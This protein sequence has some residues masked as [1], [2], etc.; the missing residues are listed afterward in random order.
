MSARLVLAL[1]AGTAPGHPAAGESVPAPLNVPLVLVEVGAPPPSFS[2]ERLAVAVETYI[3]GA[4]PRMMRLHGVPPG[5]AEVCGAARA[6]A[7]AADAAFAIWFGWSAADTSASFS[8]F[9]LPVAADCSEAVSYSVTY[10]ESDTATFYRV[11][12]LKL[13]SV[14]REARA[15]AL[16]PSE[17]PA[18]LP[19][20]QPPPAVTVELATPGALFLELGAASVL[21]P[22]RASRVTFVQAA[23]DLRDGVW[24]FGVLGFG[25]L[26][27]Q[28]ETSTA[29]ARAYVGGLVILARRAL[30]RL[31]DEAGPFGL[32]AEAGAG[33]QGIWASAQRRG[34]TQRYSLQ[35]FT[36]LF[37]AALTA[38]VTLSRPLALRFGPGVDLSWEDLT[39]FANGTTLVHSPRARPRC[40]LRLEASF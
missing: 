7:I 26:P 6:M 27:V 12:A 5:G 8:L 16:P 39:L 29:S 25:A 18:T 37:A 17:A 34:E 24:A 28:R 14:V 40:D 38:R 22:E 35:V 4:E 1:L 31:A 20:S 36:P 3:L 32:D 30:F 33:V 10:D 13:S 15:R 19:T 21:L 2:D 11:V 9:L 23:V